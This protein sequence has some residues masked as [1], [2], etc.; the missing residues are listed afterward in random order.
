MSRSKTRSK[1]LLVARSECQ[2]REGVDDFLIAAAAIASTTSRK[3][4]KERSRYGSSIWTL[5]PFAGYLLNDPPGLLSVQ[6]KVT[7]VIDA[8]E[9]LVAQ[10][11]DVVRQGHGEVTACSTGLV[12][13]GLNQARIACAA[14]VNHSDCG[15]PVQRDRV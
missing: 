15:L 5:A 2:A 4:A 12:E 10:D 1:I 7:T 9:D 14:E 6:V 11:A 3:S 13:E 8:A